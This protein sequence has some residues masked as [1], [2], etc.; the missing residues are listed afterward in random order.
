MLSVLRFKRRG[1]APC[2]PPTTST[3]LASRPASSPTMAP[4]ACRVMNAPALGHRVDQYLSRGL[5]HGPVRRLR[6]ERLR[7][8][9]R[10]RGG[11][12]LPPARNRSGSTCPRSR[13]PIRSYCGEG[14]WATSRCRLIRSELRRAFGCFVTGVTVVTAIDGEGRPRGFTANSFTSVSLDPP[15]VLV[16]IARTAGSYPAILHDSAFRHQHPERGAATDLQQVRLEG[17]RQVRARSVAAG[18]DRQPSSPGPSRGWTAAPS[19]RST[20]AII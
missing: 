19:S 6:P 14:R 11:A 3:P 1:R 4:G 20:P 10:P 13:W 15:L 18:T 7:P 16:C 17:G 5:A 12:R 8:R 9:R 2:A